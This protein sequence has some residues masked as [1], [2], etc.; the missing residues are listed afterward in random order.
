LARK[1]KDIRVLCVTANDYRDDDMIIARRVLN[2]NMPVYYSAAD[3]LLFPS[4]YESASYTTIEAMA[5]NLPVVAYRTGLFEDIEERKVG[6]I[7]NSMNVED[8]SKAIDYVLAGARI[9][10]RSL[11]EKRYSMDRFTNDYRTLAQRMT[12]K[13]I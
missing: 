5:C 6:R 13:S 4:R 7:L 2:E 8:F 10:T 9:N 12:S 11:A 1:R 3:F